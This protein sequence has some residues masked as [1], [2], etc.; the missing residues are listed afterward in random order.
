MKRRRCHH[1]FNMYGNLLLHGLNIV[2]TAVFIQEAAIIERYRE[3]NRV[4]ILDLEK[5]IKLIMYKTTPR[6]VVARGIVFTT[7]LQ[8]RV[9]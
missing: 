4:N 2:R 1:S 6:I 7:E 3:K 5:R 8:R 9:V